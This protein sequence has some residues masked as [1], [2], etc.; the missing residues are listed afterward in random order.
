VPLAPDSRL[1]RATRLSTASHATPS[2]QPLASVPNLISYLHEFFQNFSQSLAIYFELFS[3]EE[4]IYSEIA[5]E[6]APPVRR[7]MRQHAVA[8]WPP[9]TAPTPRL[10]AAVGTPR[11]CRSPSTAASPVPPASHAPPSPRP[12]VSVPNLISYLHDFFQNFS[13]SLA[14]YFEL[15]SFEEIIYSEIA[16]ERAPPLRSRAPR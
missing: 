8:A 2:P 9:C 1:A 3:F 4:I 13:Q 5:D 15:F 14:I 6:R 16:D 11:S 10:K 7:P 12:L